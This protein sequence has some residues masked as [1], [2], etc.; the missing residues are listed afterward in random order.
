LL[1]IKALTKFCTSCISPSSNIASSSTLFFS[2]FTSPK[3][4]FYS[5]LSNFFSCCLNCDWNLSVV[6]FSLLVA[7]L[8]IASKFSETTY[9]SYY[10][11]SCISL[12]STSRSLMSSTRNMD[13]LESFFSTSS[14]IFSGPSK[15]TALS[16]RAIWLRL[17]SRAI[18]VA[19]LL[20]T[21][22]AV[23]SLTLIESCSSSVWESNT[24]FYRVSFAQKTLYCLRTLS[25]K[26][27]SCLACL[28]ICSWTL[29][30]IATISIRSCLKYLPM[31]SLYFAWV[32]GRA[33]NS[34]IR[35]MSSLSSGSGQFQNTVLLS[36]F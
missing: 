1:S 5:I 18:F 31:S 32:L 20:E 33:D 34:L 24:I 3:S 8:T 2:A 30:I 15:S 19:A 29:S 23:I 36:A 9:P 11:P 25:S 27:Q 17:A 14:L 35:I 13:M 10:P 4:T 16:C 26:S 7:R 12:T 21:T 6:L 22:L 28:S